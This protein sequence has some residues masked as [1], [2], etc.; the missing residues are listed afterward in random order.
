MK[1][2]ILP[3]IMLF[4][5]GIMIGVA[6]IIPG[7]SGGTIAVIVGVFDRLLAALN[8][9]FKKFKDNLKF[10]IPL[11]IGAVAGILA[12]SRLMEYCLVKFEIQT[13]FFFV[14]LVIG[15][16]PLI[17][18]K[19]SDN[20]S[21]VKFIYAV[22][23][24][25]GA[26]SVIVLSIIQ[27]FFTEQQQA[28]TAAIPDI[29]AGNMILFFLFG[30]IASVAMVIPGISGSLVMVLLGAYDK[31][32][33]AINGITSFGDTATMVK[34]A[35]ILITFGIGVI[36]GIFSVAKGFSILLKKF[37][38]GTYVAILGLMVGSSV[39]LLVNMELYSQSYSFI[40]VAVSVLTTVAGFFTSF[41]LGR[42]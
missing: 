24:I 27:T 22:P 8:T 31:V 4:F 9:L 19:V 13:N 1:N 16:I 6:N 21:R 15:S 11:G 36:I 35:L 18:N 28:S 33:A 17:Y 7:V 38:G 5:K 37:P 2:K 26:G 40:I 32:I 30:I 42:E 39:A 14:G 25:L 10:L 41:F 3:P 12:L 20:T 23:F 29:S 34:S